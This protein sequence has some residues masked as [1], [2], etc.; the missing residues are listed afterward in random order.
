MALIIS[1]IA[2]LVI[3]FLVMIF[4][5]RKIMIQDV[6]KATSHLDELTRQYQEKEKKI[7]QEIA[8]AEAKKE[9]I[10]KEA[11]LEAEKMKLDLIQEGQKQKE[12]LLDSAHQQ[13]EEIVR[14]AERSRDLL[15]S[16]IE[17]R[18]KKN[19]ISKACELINEVLPLEFKEMVHSRWVEDLIASGFEGL[20]AIKVPKEVQEAKILTA[21]S[22][23]ADQKK[24][25]AQKLSQIL[26]RQLVL[27]EE[28]DQSL[29][30]GLQVELGSL[31]LDG[32]LKSKIL[33]KARI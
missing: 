16:E 18:I 17:E 22:L 12:K 29:I 9:E 14:Q 27:K 33:K 8:E 25:I 28:L 32:S 4:V 23:A 6:S 21:F 5:F 11:Q 2:I 30:A 19:A 1:L 31:V 24:S 15:L 7:N 26:G 20:N 10:L 13:A 3:M